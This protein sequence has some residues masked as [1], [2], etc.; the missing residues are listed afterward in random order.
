MNT[1]FVIMGLPSS[2][3]TTFLAA[4]WHLVESKE[5]RSYLLLNAYGGELEYLNTIAGEWRAYKPVPR[6]SQIGDTK[7]TIE[8]INSKTG[9]SG[10]ACFPD[11]AGEVFDRQAQKRVCKLEYIQDLSDG[12]GIL[13]FISA[14][15]KDDA[16]SIADLNER[17]PI[18]DD[19][20]ITNENIP[21]VQN[22]EQEWDPSQLPNQ[23]KIVQLLSDLIRPP[24]KPSY[25]RIAV[26]IS[27]WDITKGMD[28][29]PASWLSTNM[30]LVD[31][32][33]K[34]NGEYF[35]Y[36]VYGVSAQGASL[37]DD[38]EVER[39]TDL[40]TAS[41]RIRIVG[42]EIDSHDLTEPLVWLTSVKK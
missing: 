3:K 2:G 32:F 8:L 23:V 34:S 4:L 1:N 16:L 28:V 26:I 11:L 31:Q 41:D 12:S 35:E 20:L 27:A 21:R 25:R 39:L 38:I 33:L 30:P 7:V 18:D 42:P 9:I 19:P 37:D 22:N 10:Y 17:M 14:D 5:I 6:T 24:F 13:F 40:E 36:Q 29:D 15:V